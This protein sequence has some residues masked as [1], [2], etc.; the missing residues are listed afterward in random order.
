MG[1]IGCLIIKTFVKRN[2]NMVYF[3]LA[4][5]M[6]SSVG[7]VYAEDSPLSGLWETS[8]YGSFEDVKVCFDE[9]II[10]YSRV[11]DNDF[12]ESYSTNVENL[13]M[14]EDVFL[15]SFYRKEALL[16]KFVVVHRVERHELVGQ[17][18]LY[19]GFRNFNY[20]P[21]YLKKAADTCEE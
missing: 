17:L 14:V 4:A 6:V 19:D 12:E 16:R 7:S 3:L 5:I 10:S 9:S 21:V 20:I 18:H 2:S 11:G 8:Q 15:I 13:K 1:L